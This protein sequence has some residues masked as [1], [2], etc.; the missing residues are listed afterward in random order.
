MRKRT[1]KMSE[2]VTPSADPENASDPAPFRLEGNLDLTMAVDLAKSL[3]ALRGSSLTVD[4]SKVQHLGGQCGQILVSA[5][6]TWKA[7][8][9]SFQIV[10]GSEEFVE[11]ARLLGLR[12]A[13]QLEDV[14][15]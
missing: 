7:D 9:V 3:L 5:I 11:G 8:E 1:V 2:A 14:C 12:S 15:A 13:L 4:A 10:D 6:N